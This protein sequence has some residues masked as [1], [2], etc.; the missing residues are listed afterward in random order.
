[1]QT[2]AAFR[3]PTV[4]LLSAHSLPLIFSVEKG[5]EFRKT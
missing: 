2:Q 1:M 3:E 4:C 5:M